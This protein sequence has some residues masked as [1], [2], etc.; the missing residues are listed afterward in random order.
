MEKILTS[1]GHL[2]GNRVKKRELLRDRDILPINGIGTVPNQISKNGWFNK[3]EGDRPLRK[4]LCV[5]PT[6]YF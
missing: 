2:L 3:G 6:F 5:A 1:L 4:L